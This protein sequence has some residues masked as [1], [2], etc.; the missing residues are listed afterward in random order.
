MIASATL[1][2]R[3]TLAE[4]VGMLRNLTARHRRV[5][6]SFDYVDIQNVLGTSV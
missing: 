1:N 6:K 2:K 3:S 5:G 4:V